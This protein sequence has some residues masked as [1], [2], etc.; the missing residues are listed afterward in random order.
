MPT[1]LHIPRRFDPT[2]SWL[3]RRLVRRIGDERRAE[4]FFILCVAA[5]ALALI[6]FSY[7]V[8]TSLPQNAAGP[9]RLYAFLGQAAL[10]LAAL[11]LCLWGFRPAVTV[12]LSGDGLRI[13]QGARRVSLP[14]HQ[15]RKSTIITH[16]LFHRHYR[17]YAG[18]QAF[19]NGTGTTVLL[20]ET[21]T[22][23]VAI[24]LPPEAYTPVIEHLSRR[25]V[26]YA[27]TLAHAR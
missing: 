24:G 16:L 23:H 20:L 21:Q 15:I 26:G 3:G 18:T 1:E 25:D 11:A 2:C 22:G 5:V 9:V 17:R 10:W 4:A 12:V 8:W 14:F 6:A 7:A 27:A 13:E 19:I